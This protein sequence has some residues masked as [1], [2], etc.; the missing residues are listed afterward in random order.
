[1]KRHVFALSIM[2]ATIF[3]GSAGAQFLGDAL[4]SAGLAISEQEAAGIIAASGAINDPALT[5]VSSSAPVIQSVQT[6][7]TVGTDVGVRPR[8]PSSGTSAGGAT[9]SGGT[10]SSASSGTS[11]GGSSRPSGGATGFA[12][13]PAYAASIDPKA[14]AAWRDAFRPAGTK[15]ANPPADAVKVESFGQPY[16]YSK[17]MFFK[18][19]TGG[20]EV[21]AAP[22]GAV[23]PAKPVGAATVFGDNKPHTYYAGTFYVYDAASKGYAVVQ[24]PVGATVDYLPASAAKGEWKGSTHYEYA[25][26]HYKPYYRGSSVVYTVAGS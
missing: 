11:T 21:V 16:S 5:N 13:A 24:P 23:I 8:T 22:L 6:P 20:W 7:G 12:G 19:G 26:T 4:A 3:A 10:S 14:A 15:V 25:G 1:M 9:T 17:G 18:Q 2:A